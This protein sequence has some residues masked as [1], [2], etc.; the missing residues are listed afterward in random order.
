MGNRLLD[1][2]HT[3]PV[4]L[5]SEPCTFNLARTTFAAQLGNKFEYLAQ[6]RRANRVPLALQTT[7]RIDRYGATQCRIT[8]LGQLPAPAQR[9]KAQIFG[10]HELTHRSCIVNLGK[11]HIRRAQTRRLVCLPGRKPCHMMLQLIGI[12]R[13]RAAQHTGMN[14]HIPSARSGQTGTAGAR[15]QQGCCRTV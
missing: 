7:G 11:I 9:T 5:D 12:T 13:A 6:S 1:T 10:L 3:A 4:F 14:A 2:P 15:T 8:A